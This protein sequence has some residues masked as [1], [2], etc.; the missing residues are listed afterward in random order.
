MAGACPPQ[1]SSH[2]HAGTESERLSPTS[3]RSVS[4]GDFAPCDLS[5]T[6]APPPP[7]SAF[8]AFSSFAA[9][10][11]SRVS[12]AELSS[13]PSTPS[14]KPRS[15]C[16]TVDCAEVTQE[17]ADDGEGDVEPE[18][19]DSGTQDGARGRRSLQQMPCSEAEVYEILA[20]L[21]NVDVLCCRYMR[22]QQAR[23]TARERAAEAGGEAGEE[24][25]RGGA[26]D[27]A[28]SAPAAAPSLLDLTL[29]FCNLE[30]DSESGEI[31]YA[32]RPLSRVSS[33]SSSSSGS[34][35]A[36]SL[37]AGA[38]A[39][40]AAR[41]VAGGRGETAWPDEAVSR[42]LQ[43]LQRGGATRV[44]AAASLPASSATAGDGGSSPQTPSAPP[45]AVTRS[46][47]LPLPAGLRQR[48][49]AAA[50]LGVVRRSVMRTARAQKVLAICA[51]LDLAQNLEVQD[52]F[53]EL[54]FAAPPL[55]DAPPAKAYLVS[56]LK[57]LYAGA[58]L[59][60][61]PLSDSF[62]EAVF[63]HVSAYSRSDELDDRPFVSYETLDTRR[64]PQVFTFRTLL[65]RN[66]LGLRTWTAGF[67]LV[68][69]LATYGHQFRCVSCLCADTLSTASSPCA[70]GAP[71]CCCSAAPHA[72]CCC[73]RG[74]SRARQA[75]A[76]REAGTAAC[77]QRRARDVSGTWAGRL[78]AKLE[79]AQPRAWRRGGPAAGAQAADAPRALG[80]GAAEAGGAAAEAGGAAAEAGGA[81]VSVAASSWPAAKCCEAFAPLGVLELGSGLGVTASA[82]CALPPPAESCARP[83][84]SPAAAAAAAGCAA[85]ARLAASCVYVSSDYLPS[86]LATCAENL[87]RNGVSIASAFARGGSAGLPEAEKAREPRED[88]AGAPTAGDG[89]AT[90]TSEAHREGKVA[91]EAPNAPVVFLETFDFSDAQRRAG[92][93]LTKTQDAMYREGERRKRIFLR[94]S[95][96]SSEATLPPR[97][98]SAT[99]PADAA[100]L[101]EGESGAAFASLPQGAASSCGAAGAGASPSSPPRPV[102]RGVARASSLGC[103]RPAS[104]VLLIVGADLIYDRG[105]NSLLANALSLLL[106]APLPPR[107]A[108]GSA[109]SPQALGE[110][111]RVCILCSAVRDDATRAHFLQE[112][113]RH[114]LAHFEVW[115]A[116]RRVQI[117]ARNF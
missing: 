107:A 93:L 52:A 102:G 95:C 23:R 48:A 108:S 2:E 75:E 13:A 113:E 43:R 31:Q 54:L 8:A 15:S 29:D 80:E 14:S 74:D 110:L 61:L 88:G 105:L 77:A 10:Q 12:S 11:G 68:E 99:S 3:L 115:K 57:C 18:E 83:C 26:G 34:L 51:F 106:R 27:A 45:G 109:V 53:V 49:V 116:N 17:E 78:L 79:A 21:L 71:P 84:A 76:A 1:Q 62:A 20:E 40:Q 19:D 97:V 85:G 44:A 72:E 38:Q 63:K 64:P 6:A 7:S 9:E 89:A 82:L 60:Q 30:R 28:E 16:S 117:G 103:S 73:G 22:R 5:S 59:R 112:L 42:L 87:A 86:I 56:L 81:R 101:D 47:A 39:A 55:R 46:E 33:F 91:A 69:Y 92:A 111:K 70:A 66:E 24:R 104:G 25:R 35:A 37:A 114:A 96:A 32:A 50:L 90:G 65:Y 36:A 67:F 58:E 98:S 41:V 4:P 94:H 100:R